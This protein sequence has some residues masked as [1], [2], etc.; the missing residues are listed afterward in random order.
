M[1]NSEQWAVSSGQGGGKPTFL[2]P[3]YLHLSFNNCLKGFQPEINPASKLTS[4]VGKAGSPPL[5]VYPSAS[6]HSARLRC[7][8]VNIG[9]SR[10]V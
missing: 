5:V 8:Q 7:L 9:V 10:K 6:R 4:Q 1:K 2:T 3:S